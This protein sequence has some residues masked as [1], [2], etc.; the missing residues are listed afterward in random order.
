GAGDYWCVQRASIHH[1]AAHA[2]NR[3][4]H[5]VRRGER[6]RA[7]AD[8]SHGCGTR[9]H[10]HS[11]WLDRQPID[12]ARDRHA[13]MGSVGVRPGHAG[14]CGRVAAR[15]GRGG[16]LD[17]SSL[18][19]QGR[20][21]SRDAVRVTHGSWRATTKDENGPRHLCF[22]FNAIGSYFH[23]SK[24]EMRTLLE[25]F[26]YALRMLLK[27]PGFTVVAVLTL[28]LGLGANTAIFSVVN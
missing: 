5:G 2:R 27:S 9:G 4:P 12:S 10:W 19:H 26:R 25:D 22:V 20:S 23:R 18:C 7:E 1:R 13:V 3:H 17:S 8:H 15:D 14:V 24:V 21:A 28:A 11:H 6:P 16:L